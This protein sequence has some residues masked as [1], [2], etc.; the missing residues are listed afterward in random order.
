MRRRDEGRLQRQSSRTV[1]RRAGEGT[2]GS[3]NSKL[4]SQG[5]RWG[6]RDREEGTGQTVPFFL[7]GGVG[8]GEGAGGFAAEELLVDGATDMTEVED[9]DGDAVG[10]VVDDG[11]L[12]EM[13]VVEEVH[14][15][16]ERRFRGDGVLDGVFHPLRR[17][18]G[19]A[20]LEM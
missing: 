3:R 10:V 19:V 2:G 8:F 18:G 9:A 11:N 6:R 12:I 5:R 15:L 14:G 1:E 16:A 20:E 7:S 13:E 4:E 17:L